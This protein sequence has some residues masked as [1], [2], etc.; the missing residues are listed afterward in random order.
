MLLTDQPSV[1]K[2]SQ[3][4]AVHGYNC[5]FCKFQYLEP[6]WL[7]EGIYKK[8]MTMTVHFIFKCK[9]TGVVTICF[10]QDLQFGSHLEI[11]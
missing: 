1:L 10:L 9:N 4:I 6:Y 3:L 11:F 2:K 7:K 5:Q 8:K